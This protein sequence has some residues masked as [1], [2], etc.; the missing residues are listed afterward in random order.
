MSTFQV[1]FLILAAWFLL[2]HPKKCQSSTTLASVEDDLHNQELELEDYKTTL[3]LIYMGHLPNA[4][5]RRGRTKVPPFLTL[6]KVPRY[7][8]P[9]PNVVKTPN[10]S[11]GL[12]FTKLKNS[13]GLMS[14]SKTDIF[15]N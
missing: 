13:L 9:K 6:T 2:C 4:F 7:L 1:Q 10:L 12:V 11:C 15:E 14:F 5:Y 8:I 3:T